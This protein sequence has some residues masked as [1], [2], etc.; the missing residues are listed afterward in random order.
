MYQNS[1][2]SIAE[3]SCQLIA[4]LFARFK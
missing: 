3:T 2:D 4:L 1:M